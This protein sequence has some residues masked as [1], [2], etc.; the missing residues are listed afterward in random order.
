MGQPEAAVAAPLPHPARKERVR[1][2]RRN[3]APAD[4]DGLVPNGEGDQLEFLRGEAVIVGGVPVLQ[5]QARRRSQF[6]SSSSVR[7]DCSKM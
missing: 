4:P 1:Q 6:F 5:A 3:V 7:I 2:Q